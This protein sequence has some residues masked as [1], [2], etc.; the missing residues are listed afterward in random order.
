VCWIPSQFALWL[1]V[2]V[3]SSHPSSLSNLSCSR[4]TVHNSS[5]ISVCMTCVV[6][7]ISLYY[8]ML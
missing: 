2:A 4:S 1:S 6:D 5:S 7:T 3:P 8:V